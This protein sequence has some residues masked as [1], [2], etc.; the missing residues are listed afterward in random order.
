MRT[1]FD[2]SP[3]VLLASLG[4]LTL[5]GACAKEPPTAVPEE[6]ASAA[7]DDSVSVC[8]R[9]GSAGTITRI[10][11]SQLAAAASHG[12]YATGLLVSHAGG[13]PEDGIHFR[14]ITDAVASARAGRLARG[15]RSSAACRITINIA[16]GVYAGT[17]LPTTNRTLEQLPFVVDVPDITLHGSFVMQLDATGRATGNGVGTVATS[18]VPVEPATYA[19]DG[20]S[21]PIIFA[22]GHLNGPAGNGLVV[23]GFVFRAGQNP[24]TAFWEFA[25]FSIR[26]TGLVVRG[27]RFEGPFDVPFD[28]RESRAIIAQ[29]QI[30]G[31]SLCDMCLAGPGAYQVTGNRLLAGA[32][33]GILTIPIARLPGAPG[34]QTSELP[35]TAEVSADIRNNEVDDHDLLPIGAGIRFGAVGLGA[36]NVLGS[37]HYTV[38]NNLLVHNRFGI[39]VDAA[40]PVP[41]TAL[42]GD[43]DVSF[44]GNQ[45]QRSCQTDLLVAFTRHTTALKLTNFPYLLHSTYALSLN[46]N[47]PWDRIWY[48]DPAGYGNSFIVDGLAVPPGERQ[49]YD[50]DECPGS[51][52]P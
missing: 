29:N 27:N 21:A 14:R 16:D 11:R 28:L 10:H 9:S 32:L 6:Q 51:K 22:N 26:V 44:S 39:E 7:L 31:T 25:V 38:E 13:Q 45:I 24:E 1:H 46:G 35:A 2:R 8:H 15:E 50:A 47:I 41:E 36:P 23:E 4:T 49:F 5:L 48:S 19:D 20:A 52:A 17:A 34:M 12:D 18:V 42:K 37:G 43:M 3:W 40:F 30:A 33:E